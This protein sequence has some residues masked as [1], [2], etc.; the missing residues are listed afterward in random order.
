M[1]LN[2]ATAEGADMS[3]RKAPT[4]HPSTAISDDVIGEIAYRVYLLRL[5]PSMTPDESV[6]TTLERDGKVVASDAIRRKNSGFM[7]SMTRDCLHVL[8]DLGMVKP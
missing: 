2:P 7:Q 1:T 4:R 3:E 8:V 6:A 5:E